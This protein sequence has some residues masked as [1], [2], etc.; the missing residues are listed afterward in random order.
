MQ[1]A[2]RPLEVEAGFVVAWGESEG[3][4]EGVART[5]EFPALERGYAEVEV[6]RGREGRIPRVERG[7][8][9]GPLRFGTE[10]R[11]RARDAEPKQR[12]GIER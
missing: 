6:G 11:P 5:L 1:G 7:G 3:V 9:E 2:K 4:E 10:S 8:E 12:L